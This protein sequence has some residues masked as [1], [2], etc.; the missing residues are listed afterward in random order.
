M[1]KLSWKQRHPDRVKEH[2]R[3]YVETH[4]EEINKR[5]KIRRA[6][7]SKEQ[8]E[9]DKM[10][11]REKW[12]SCRSLVIRHYGAKCVCCKENIEQFLT[13]DHI[14]NDG[15]EH[16]R[17]I[18]SGIYRWLIKNNYPTGF[19]ILCWN[20]NS[21]KGMYRECPH[22][23]ARYKGRAYTWHKLENNCLVQD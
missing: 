15:A 4:R 23:S 12:K 7:K 5:E 19:Q 13:I 3:K 16:R 22:K 14:N 1:K 18:G 2:R 17:I 20:C 8:K 6:N 21:S 9:I 10:K 11:N